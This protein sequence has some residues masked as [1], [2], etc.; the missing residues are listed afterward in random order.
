M[1]DVEKDFPEVAAEAFVYWSTRRAFEAVP[2][3]ARQKY[4]TDALRLSQER[5]Q[6]AVLDK[7]ETLTT[8]ESIGYDLDDDSPIVVKA[9]EDTRAAL[10]RMLP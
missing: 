1:I 10:R 5:L 4:Q 9:L 2:E 6:R 3:S 8:A 7:I